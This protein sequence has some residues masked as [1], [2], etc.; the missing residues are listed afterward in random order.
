MMNLRLVQTGAIEITEKE[1]RKDSRPTSSLLKCGEFKVL[2]DLEHPRKDG[3]E[4]TAALDSLGVAAA[5]TRA[6]IFTHLHPDL[7]TL[8]DTLYVRHRPGHTRGSVIVFACIKE[9]R[10]PLKHRCCV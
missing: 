7:R 1:G 2:I 8:G 5:D 9:W 4:F 6:I 3:V 10:R